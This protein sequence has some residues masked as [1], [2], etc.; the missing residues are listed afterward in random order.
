MYFLAEMT[1]SGDVDSLLPRMTT[2]LF[3]IVFQLENLKQG[4]KSEPIK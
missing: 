3:L 2:Q 1:S 4:F